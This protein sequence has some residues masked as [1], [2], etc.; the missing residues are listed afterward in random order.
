VRDTDVER[1]M[2]DNFKFVLNEAVPMEESR[3]IEFKEVKGR[4]PIDS[5]KNKADVGLGSRMT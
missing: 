2:D 1:V 3:P 5:I 4:N